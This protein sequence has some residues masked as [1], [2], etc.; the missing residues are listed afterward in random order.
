MNALSWSA[1]SILD[2]LDTTR[3]IHKAL[4]GNTPS[5]EKQHIDAVTF[6][7]KLYD[8]LQD[9]ERRICEHDITSFREQVGPQLRTIENFFE[10]M[11]EKLNNHEQSMSEQVKKPKSKAAARQMR[12]ALKD[13]VTAVDEARIEGQESLAAISTLSQHEAA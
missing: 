11:R 4:Q 10:K 9:I 2:A 5:S 3:K 12:W 7:M 13:L 8:V 6:I 1:I